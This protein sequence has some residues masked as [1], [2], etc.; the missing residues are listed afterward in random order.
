MVDADK[1]Y[2]MKRVLICLLALLA[3]TLP[4]LADAQYADLENDYGPPPYNDVENGQALQLAAYVLAPFGYAL[5]WGLTRPLHK[6]ATDTPLAPI[7]SGDTEIRYFGE[8]ANANLLPPGTFA[9]FQMP[10]N[11]NAIDSSTTPPS[12]YSYQ[13]N[14]LPPVTKTER[15]NAQGYVSGSGGQSAFH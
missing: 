11:P 7:L 15:Y 3:L 1:V 12:T 2:P 14:V 13:T 6:L 9:P 10:A 8:T 5:E 4:R